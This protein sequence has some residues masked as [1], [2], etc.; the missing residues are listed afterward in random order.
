MSFQHFNLQYQKTDDRKIACKFRGL[1]ILSTFLLQKGR[2]FHYTVKEDIIHDST[3][4][5]VDWNY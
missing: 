3:F 1:N 2:K 4:F 5:H